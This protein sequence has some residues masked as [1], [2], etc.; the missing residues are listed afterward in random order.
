MSVL[1]LAAI[2]VTISASGNQGSFLS[3][4]RTQPIKDAYGKP[5]GYKT[6][7]LYSGFQ[8][9][10]AAKRGYG[11][12]YGPPQPVAHQG[13]RFGKYHLTI[14]YARPRQQGGYGSSGQNGYQ[15][16]NDNA[17]S[18]SGGYGV[19]SRR[20]I[21]YGDNAPH[22]NGG[23]GDNVHSNGGGYGDN[24]HSN[25][26][27]YGDNIHSNAGGYGDNI[28]SNAGGY[29]D[30]I[31]SNAGGYGDNIHSNAGGYGDNIHSN[32]GGYGENIHSNSGGYGD[33]VG[34]N[35]GGYGGNVHGNAGGYGI[36]I[37]GKNDGYIDEN[38]GYGGP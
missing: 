26:G 23:Y 4:T 25:A 29:G 11:S 19:N 9:L 3:R 17:H 24:I 35:N 31:H 20:N 30:N 15:G 5:S 8:V 13:V 7:R 37:R 21:G 6:E 32:A 27:G 34:N 18:K 16:T 12:G 36:N 1:H 38:V 22:N 2:M 14:N 28:H 33:N 10:P